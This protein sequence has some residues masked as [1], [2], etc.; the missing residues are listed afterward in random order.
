MRKFLISLGA[1][2]AVILGML[3]TASTASA[4]TVKSD[5]IGGG[6]GNGN[7]I[8]VPTAT[9][10]LGGAAAADCAPSGVVGVPYP[11]DPIPVGGRYG[12]HSYGCAGGIAYT[13]P[14]YG[15][16]AYATEWR[17]L[18]G[19]YNGL[20]SAYRLHHG[21]EGEL[22]GV[23]A[24]YLGARDRYRGLYQRY[25]CTV[26]QVSYTVVATPEELCGCAPS[27]TSVVYERRVPV[28]AVHAG[29]YGS[30]H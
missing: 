1:A 11:V 22:R 2:G 26:P 3:A 13:N 19:R 30:C 10:L 28:G 6:I 4:A 27:S 25:G 12:C 17:T 29:G 5:L 20:A 21:N 24:N 18:A 23:Y 14:C 7:S 16:G 8:C 15:L 9:G